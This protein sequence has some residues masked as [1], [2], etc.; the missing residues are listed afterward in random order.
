[1]FRYL[2]ALALVTLTALVLAPSSSPAYAAPDWE[3]VGADID[4]E[5]AGDQSGYSVALNEDGTILAVGEWKNAVVEGI[6]GHDLLLRGALRS[7]VAIKRFRGYTKVREPLI[8]HG[9]RSSNPPG[10]PFCKPCDPERG[11]FAPSR[12]LW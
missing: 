6:E 4:G 7:A 11:A 10:S 2:T 8:L 3:Q 1:M 9:W 12:F 5:S